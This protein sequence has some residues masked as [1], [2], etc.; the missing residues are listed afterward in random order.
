MVGESDK[1]RLVLVHVF[2]QS[3][4]TTGGMLALPKRRRQ[5]VVESWLMRT[6]GGIATMVEVEECILLA[7]LGHLLFLVVLAEIGVVDSSCRANGGTDACR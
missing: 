4:S 5:D 6:R 1:L 3:T 7:E 2:G